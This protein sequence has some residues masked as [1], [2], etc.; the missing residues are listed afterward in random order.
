MAQTNIYLK[1]GDIK[2]ESL[3]ENHGEW[4]ELELVYLGRG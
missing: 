4:I 1:L 2:G 3:D